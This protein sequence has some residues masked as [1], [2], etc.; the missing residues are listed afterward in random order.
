MFVKTFRR[1]AA[2]G[3]VRAHGIG[4]LIRADLDELRSKL[5]SVVVSSC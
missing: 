4:R 5:L 1:R 2:D 3:A